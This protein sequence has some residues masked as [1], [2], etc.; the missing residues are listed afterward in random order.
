MS[1][2]VFGAEFYMT[3]NHTVQVLSWFLIVLYFDITL[4]A[5]SCR[6]HKY[7]PFLTPYTLRTSSISNLIS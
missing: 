2:E 5:I 7:L 3:C 4:L 6:A 1:E